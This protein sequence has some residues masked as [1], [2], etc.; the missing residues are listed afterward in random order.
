MRAWRIVAFLLLV[1][2]PAFAQ[3]ALS[4][5]PV[6]V[7]AELGTT[8]AVTVRADT[9]RLQADAAE[10]RL[11]FDP[12]QLSVTDVS[13]IGSV[14]SSWPTAPT[15]SNENGT[16]DFS[17]WAAKQPFSGD[18][19][20]VTVTFRPLRVGIGRIDF[21]S[22][23]VLSMSGQETNITESMQG[24]TYQIVPARIEVPTP[25]TVSDQPSAQAPA[26]AT[27][28][29]PA[30]APEVV[31]PTSSSSPDQVSQAAA[32]ASFTGGTLGGVATFLIGGVIIGAIISIVI[33]L[34]GIG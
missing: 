2:L 13:S 31:F 21:V 24:A 23:S 29:A 28:S 15:Y 8:F 7:D 19:Q 1:P 22:G 4:L 3:A 33:F 26:R 18:A 5:S 12:T 17:G 25:D 20:L 27:R 32:A 11:S 10:A 34:F 6:Q 14:L 30:P 16:V 9:G